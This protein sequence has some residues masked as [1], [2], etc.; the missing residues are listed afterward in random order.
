MLVESEGLSQHSSLLE[1]GETVGT[2][3]V[4]QAAYFHLV[5]REHIVLE[6]YHHMGIPLLASPIVLSQS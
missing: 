6:S 5:Q 2:I 4:S 1:L 3:L